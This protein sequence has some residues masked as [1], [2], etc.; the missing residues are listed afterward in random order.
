MD[1]TVGRELSYNANDEFTL[2]AILEARGKQQDFKVLVNV[3]RFPIDQKCL[4]QDHVTSKEEMRYCC[5]TNKS[6]FQKYIRSQLLHVDFVSPV[7]HGS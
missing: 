7:A 1:D 6:F 2:V 3:C 4:K 5:R